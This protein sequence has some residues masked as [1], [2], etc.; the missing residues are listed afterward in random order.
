MESACNLLDPKKIGKNEFYT[1]ST[2]KTP[3]GYNVEFY[4][5]DRNAHFICYTFSKKVA[6][7]LKDYFENLAID[8]E[9]ELFAEILKR[10]AKK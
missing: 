3:E 5:L 7:N 8:E 9:K 10:D 4:D 6:D 1:Y 2:E